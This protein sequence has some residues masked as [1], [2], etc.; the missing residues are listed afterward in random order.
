MVYKAHLLTDQEDGLINVAVKTLKGI[1]FQKHAAKTRKI[2]YTAGIIVDYL[3]IV[4]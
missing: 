4:L 2:N 3:S 1:N